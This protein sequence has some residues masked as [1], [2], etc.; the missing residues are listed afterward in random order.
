MMREKTDALFVGPGTF[1]N[2]PRVQLAVLTARHALPAA[3]PTRVYPE[4]GGLMS[5]GADVIDAFR[6]V[7]IYTARILKGAKPADL[8]VLQSG[9]R[10]CVGRLRRR[11]RWK[12]CAGHAARWDGCRAWPTVA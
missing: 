9:R 3:Y 11:C 12:R 1:F 4:S 5:Y 7:G 8:P 6:Q 2:T 10:P